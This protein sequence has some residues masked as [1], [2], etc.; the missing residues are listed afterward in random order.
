MTQQ[1]IDLGAGPDSTDGD[2]IYVAFT[3]TN[4]NFTELY[5]IIG[6][7]GTTNLS[8]N[9]ITANYFYTTGTVR[10][11]N[12]NAFA[13]IN[14]VGN[15]VAA[16]FL[17]P[18][19]QPVG[20]NVTAILGNINQDLIPYLSNTYNI[21]SSTNTFGSGYFDTNL[22]LQGS[23]L[24][25]DGTNLLL[26]G[27]AI[28]G[29][30][31][32]TYDAITGN[33]TVSTP[34]EDFTVDIGVGR[35]D[36]P[37]FNT[38]TATTF[39]GNIVGNISGNLAVPGN[40]TEIIFNANGAAG[41]S[42]N[43]KFE[44][45]ANLLTVAGTANISSELYVGTNVTVA[46]FEV[47][48]SSGEVVTSRLKD[49]GVTSGTYG[50]ASAVPV[51][52]IDD[53]GRITFANTAAVS[54]VSNVVYDEDTGNL[55]ISTSSGEDFTVDI[56]TGRSDDPVFANLTVRGTT[57][58]EIFVVN[59]D[60]QIGGNTTTDGLYVTGN[61]LVV[62]SGNV[63]QR[64]T[65]AQEGMLYFNSNSDSIEWYTGSVWQAPITDYT[66]VTA[67]L[68]QGDNTTVDFPLPVSNATTAGTMV[69]ING[70]IQQPGIAYTI[71]NATITFSEAPRITDNVDIRI[72][73]TTSTV[74]G[75]SDT[76][77]QTQILMDHDYAGDNKIYIKNAGN[78]TA[79]LEANSQIKVFA[80]IESTSYTTGSMVV[81]GGIGVSGN[82]YIND[83]LYAVAKSFLIDHP[84][85]P[86]Y[87]LQYA[88]L[89]G[90]ENGV[91]IR[92]RSKTN[93]IVLPEYWTALVD[94]DTIT[95]DLTPVGNYQKLYVRSTDN[96][97]II[98]A[99]DTEA[100][101]DYYYTVW[102][103]RKDIDKLTIEH[104]KH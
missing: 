33:L 88:S 95:V 77:A 12:I 15:V 71:A 35:S 82:V 20:G 55:T 39:Y 74:T 7:N 78:N 18:N 94:Q 75:I 98:V 103:E 29:V 72:F 80:N 56:G 64:P 70:I 43:F 73:T 23:V 97:C 9:T 2:S 59:A 25:S 93:C 26:D 19:G 27:V 79:I 11:G 36:D 62:P 49:S 96:N 53:K 84:T 34:S 104:Q 48:D 41:S 68:Q 30:S 63:E 86:G 6:S 99:S 42:P 24:T 76:Y 61:T 3:K 91:Y 22:V 50:N 65:N 37:V 81:D 8:G 5:T 13:D 87:Q 40:P 66:I 89:E 38:V 67:N 46:G 51:I 100:M 16:Q 44:S 4:E 58:T 17:Y 32:V 31:D 83:T 54:G 85:K 21:G 57:T 45:S 69:S 14:T 1:L 90:P 10:A 52:T 28:A 60:A 92:G 102:A 101:F 47:I